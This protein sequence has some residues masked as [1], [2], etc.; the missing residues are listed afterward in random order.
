MEALANFPGEMRFILRWFFLPEFAYFMEGIPNS[1]V[2]LLEVRVLQGDASSVPLQ[3]RGLFRRVK[4]N[5]AETV[6]AAGF[7]PLIK[8]SK[9]IGL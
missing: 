3:E 7:S 2:D 8:A 1:S 9:E 4:L 5:A 6:G